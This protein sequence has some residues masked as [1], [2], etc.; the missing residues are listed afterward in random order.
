[1]ILVLGPD[2][3]KNHAARIG[4]VLTTEETIRACLRL[5]P[6]RMRIQHVRAPVGPPPCEVIEEEAAGG[7]RAASQYLTILRIQG[8]PAR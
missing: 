2:G 3:A 4:I 7:L 1:M 6:K 5:G 8:I